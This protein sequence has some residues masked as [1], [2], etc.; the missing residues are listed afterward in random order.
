M[1]GTGTRQIAA[2]KVYEQVKV[3]EEEKKIIHRGTAHTPPPPPLV[4]ITPP[5]SP[6]R[7]IIKTDTLDCERALG[8]NMI[9]QRTP[10]DH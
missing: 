6:S 8:Q 1:S 4:H 2:V 5:R 9:R 3:Y 10:L 7:Q